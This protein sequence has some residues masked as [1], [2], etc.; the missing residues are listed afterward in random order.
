M[1]SHQI[2]EINKVVDWLFKTAVPAGMILLWN[3]SSQI[4]TVTVNQ[5]RIE[6]HIHAIQ[7]NQAAFQEQFDEYDRQHI[8][9]FKVYD[10]SKIKR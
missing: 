8:E 3:L 9:F 7:K 1:T 2:Y 4:N 10:L 6:T 5:A